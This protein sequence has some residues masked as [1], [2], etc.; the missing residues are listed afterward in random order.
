M[1]R[2]AIALA[3]RAAL[4]FFSSRRGAIPRGLRITLWQTHSWIKEINK[5]RKCSDTRE[6]AQ[7]V[8][9]TGKQPSPICIFRT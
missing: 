3:A 5:V 8:R 2:D 7:T 1:K 9:D 4:I 6:E